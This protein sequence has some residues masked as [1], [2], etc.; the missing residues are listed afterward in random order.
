M[1]ILIVEDE[2]IISEGIFEYLTERNYT[3][4]IA[5]DGQEAIDKFEEKKVDLVLL[6]IML[7]KING[8]DVLKQIRKKSKIPVLMLTSFNDDTYKITAF[9]SLCDRIYRKT[10]LSSCIRSKNYG[11]FKKILWRL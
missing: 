4:T 7:P 5:K 9:S 3:C 2:D 11:S 8:L 1:H 10:F 6:D